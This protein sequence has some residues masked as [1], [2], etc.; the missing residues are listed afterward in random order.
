[1]LNVAMSLSHLLL[2]KLEQSKFW[3]LRLSPA[4]GAPLAPI[5]TGAK[6]NR[7]VSY[8]TPHSGAGMARFRSNIG[9]G[10]LETIAPR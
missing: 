8:C 4:D 7:L 10:H 9:G 5:I 2:R 3:Q 6:N 1:M